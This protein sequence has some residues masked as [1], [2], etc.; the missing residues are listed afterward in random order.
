MS[1]AAE[2]VIERLDATRQ[3][4]WLVSLLASTVLA[5]CGSVGLFMG[6]MAADALMGLPR[7]WL[8]AMAAAWTLVTVAM[9]VAVGR[10]LLRGQRRLGGHRPAGR[11]RV[12]RAGQQP[13]QSGA[14][15]RRH[16][17]CACYIGLGRHTECAEHPS[18]T[19]IRRSARRPCGRRPAVDRVRFDRAAAK[20]SRWRRF[21]HCMQTPRDLAESFLVLAVLAAV[22]LLGPA[23]AA[24]LG[25]G[26][27]AALGPLGVC[28]LAGIGRDCAGQAER[29]RSA[30]RRG[31]RDFGRNPQ[32]G[33]PTVPRMV[34]R[35]CRGRARVAAGNGRR[36]QEK[37][38]SLTV[39]AVLQSF[40]YRL[41]IGDSQTPF[42]AVGV[43]ASRSSRTRR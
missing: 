14:A 32:P 39:P 2:N 8:V 42:Y 22:A 37:N 33:R 3:K 36:R 13:D 18:R 9:A 25:L 29:H 35:N 1:P 28:P 7:L 20:E 19:W 11:N 6:F 27:C 10:R 24:Q 43:R 12:S 30:G 34:V 31:R 41:E 38:Y 17:A 23:L 40:K 21:V 4:W 15:F 16:T 26:V 5:A